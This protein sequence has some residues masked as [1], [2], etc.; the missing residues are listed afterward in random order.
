MDIEH[1]VLGTGRSLLPNHPQQAQRPLM[2]TRAPS[3]SREGLRGG[4]PHACPWSWLPHPRGRMTHSVLHWT[5]IY[6]APTTWLGSVLGT[7]GT[8]GKKTD[9]VLPSCS[10]CSSGE[11]AHLQVFKLLTRRW[12]TGMGALQETEVTQGVTRKKSSDEEL[13]RDMRPNG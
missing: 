4:G 7:G 6:G 13:T 11:D 1:G 12:Q 2:Q 10:S 9:G 8:A 3:H 5:N